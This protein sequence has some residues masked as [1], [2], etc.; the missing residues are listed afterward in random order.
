M[1]LIDLVR[2]RDRA[3][4]KMPEGLEPCLHTADDLAMHSLRLAA[5]AELHVGGFLSFDEM[6]AMPNDLGWSVARADGKHARPL[7]LRIAAVGASGERFE[8]ARAELREASSAWRPLP[9]R[10]P[11]RLKDVEQARLVIAIEGPG[12]RSTDT[13]EHSGAVLLGISEAVPLRRDLF[14]YARGNGIEIGPGMSP[15]VLPSPEVDVRYLEQYEIDK[16]MAMYGKKYAGKVPEQ[17]RTLWDRYIVGDAQRLENIPD[18]S[19][20][21]IFSS[22]VFEHLVNPLGTLE[23]WRRKLRRGGHV[24]GVVPDAN[25]CFDLRQPL[26]REE[27]WLAEWRD[28]VWSFQ[29]HHYEKWCRYTAPDVTP[30]SLRQRGYAIH[31]HYYTPVTFG[32][33]LQIATERLGYA[34]YQVRSC[35]NSKDFTWLVEA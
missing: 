13:Q 18:G 10:W 1:N 6:R 4:L 21:F 28:G 12:A 9:L 22:H 5:G 2:R 30:E 8:V 26:S 15:Q 11:A 19:L 35:R 24:L 29:D 33:L 34:K 20:D 17:V 32:R 14:E 23:V 27:D 16:W 3:I 25:N 7:A 31:A